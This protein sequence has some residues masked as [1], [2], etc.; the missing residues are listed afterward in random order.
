MPCASSASITGSRSVPSGS[1]TTYTNHDRSWSASSG[2]GKPEAVDVGQQ[3]RVARGDLGAAGQDPVE[4]LE[5]A[6]PDRGPDVVD[7]VVEPEPRVVEPAAAVGA[8]LVAQ[9]LEQLPRLLR[10]RRHDAALAGRDLLVRVERPDG[11]LALRT[12]RALPVPRSER[13]ARVVD[14]RQPVPAPRSLAIRPIRS[15]TRRCRRRRSPSCAG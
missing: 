10:P 12:E 13:L 5:L 8:T 3:L 11:V 1:S 4:L 9:A 6:D 15:G 14:Q 7:A 2:H